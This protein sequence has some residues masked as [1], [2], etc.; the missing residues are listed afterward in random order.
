M[1]KQKKYCLEKGQLQNIVTA[2]RGDPDACPKAEEFIEED[3]EMGKKQ[4]KKP[5]GINIVDRVIS[6]K[7]RKIM[8]SVLDWF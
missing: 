3:L 4:T 1:A 8:N 7:V 2:A 5:Q 6:R